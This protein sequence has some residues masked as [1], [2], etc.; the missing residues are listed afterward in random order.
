MST[1]PTN[2]LESLLASIRRA[3]RSGLWSQGVTL[4]RDS[5]VAVESR[6]AEEIVLRVRAPGRAVPPTVVLYPTENEWECD[7]PSRVSPCEHVAA[8]AIALGVQE[9][10]TAAAGGATEA[11]SGAGGSAAAAP[12]MAL[13]PSWARVGYRFTRATEGL[14]LSRVLVA[15]DGA[16]APLPGTLTA[17][18]ADPARAARAQVEEA[19]LQADRLLEVG[20][21]GARGV[22]SP[23]KLDGLLRLLAGAGRT[24]LDGRAVEISDEEILPRSTLVDAA[25]NAGAPEVRLTIAADP[26]VR[27]TLSPGVA[28]CEEDGRAALHRLGETELTGLWLQHLPIHRSFVAAEWGELVTAVLPDL[29]RRTLVDVRSRRL[30]PV[31]RDLPPRI[32]LQLDQLGAGLSVLPALVYGSPPVARIDNGKLVHLRGPVPVRDTPL[33]QRTLERLREE[34]GLL[35]GRRTNYAGPEAA[36]FVEK[37]RTWRGDLSGDAAG[38]VRPAATL[39]PRLR[40]ST[41]PQGADGGVGA[42]HF[43]LSFAASGGAGD[44]RRGGGDGEGTVDAAAVVRAW[45][46]GL[47]IVPLAGGGWAALPLGWLQKH[48]QR[49][50]DLLAAREADGRLARHALPALAALCAELEHPAPPGLDGLAPLVAGFERLPEAA[51]PPDLTATLRAYQRQGVSWLAFLRRAGLGGILADDMGLGKTLQALCAFEGRTLVVC[52]TSVIFNWRAELGRFRPGLKVAVYHG[53]GRALDAAADVTLTSYALLRLDARALGAVPWRA[54]VLDEAQAIKNPDS[55][56]ARA[57][58][59]LPAS[60]RLALTGTPVEN[61]LDELW[62][63]MH[64]ANRGFLGGRSDFAERHARPIAEGQPGA[65]A[66]LRQRVRPFLLRRL[67]QDVAPELPPRTDAVLRV[68][69]GDSERAVYDAVRAAAQKDLL[70]Y[71]QDGGEGAGGGGKGVMKALEALLRLRQAACHPAL[72]PGQTA[73]SSSKVEALTEAL[74]TAVAEG[75]KALVFSQWTS[76]L[77]LIEPALVAAELPF[78]RLDGSTRDRGGVVEGFQQAGGPP[79]MLVSLKAGGSGLNLTAADHVFLCDPWWNPAVEAQAADRT[80]RIGQQRPVFVYRLVAADT[81]EERILALQDSKRAL[82]DAAL[83]DGAAAAGLTKDDLL[84]LLA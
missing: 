39:E 6:D 35:P 71:F 21:G 59:A 14:R 62:S 13:A 11:A 19:D 30:P 64:F 7:C 54:V 73:A 78:V 37:L 72:V 53:A 12:K 5:A 40:L 68:E 9:A 43:D 48:G 38:I 3:C 36:R 70:A 79:V 24:Q 17:L 34:L 51:L 31:V 67:K 46:E 84:A 76:L 81:V 83:G 15:P 61:R 28:L 49:V 25:G 22:L 26:R 32:V 27:A 69:L 66:A 82:M 56:T 23:S 47:G 55:Q 42:V 52:P 4:A 80:H 45:Q 8:A 18:L 58:Y 1:P 2:A 75:H 44:G 10:D 60:F 41:D 20:G 57:A 74:E 16:E 77:D 50:A 63:L 33:E 29:A 65:A